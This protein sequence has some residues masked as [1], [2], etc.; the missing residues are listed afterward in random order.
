MKRLRITVEGMHCS[1]CALNVAKSIKKV[2]GVKDANAS[3][4]TK[5]CLVDAEDS[6]NK[7]E[8]KKA[9]ARVGYKTVSIEED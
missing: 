1:S 4:L 8:L 3:L 2:N 5:K 9:V 6:V 7:E